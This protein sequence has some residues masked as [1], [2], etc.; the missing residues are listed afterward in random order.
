M[1]NSSNSA[2]AKPS[3][4][5]STS[6]STH[7]DVTARNSGVWLTQEKAKQLIH[8]Y[9]DNTGQAGVTS[10][11]RE[12]RMFHAE[13][14]IRS[15]TG[16]HITSV[17]GDRGMAKWICGETRE[18]RHS[19]W[20]AVQTFIQSPRFRAVVPLIPAST[21][22]AELI[23]TANSF[24]NLYGKPA[25]SKRRAE[26]SPE[27]FEQEER[28]LRGLLGSWFKAT[29]GGGEITLALKAERVGNLPCAKIAYVCHST[30]RKVSATGFAIYC[31][32]EFHDDEINRFLLPVW[33]R[34]DPKT[35]STLES[36]LI[37]C[38]IS[39]DCHSLSVSHN[40]RHYFYGFDEPSEP[41]GPAV[42]V[43]LTRIPHDKLEG[44]NR[45]LDMLLENVLPHGAA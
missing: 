2:N 21:G 29:P 41:R 9:L 22:G 4:P 38:R 20:L 8:D 6:E 36:S 44:R 5:A 12:L 45:I 15:P 42:F 11:M 3:G 18:L 1:N 33:R 28:A 27:Y 14:Q 25:T 24:L 35:G 39:K 31:G 23:D 43:G 40:T 32:S 19:N 13:N 7:N 34:K 10:L 37:C 30:N 26:A 17:P 16:E